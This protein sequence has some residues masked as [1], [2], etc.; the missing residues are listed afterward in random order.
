MKAIAK[1]DL[2]YTEK[3]LGNY[4]PYA[5]FT[6]DNKYNVCIDSKYFETIIADDEN[7]EVH[8]CGEPKDLED[9]FEFIESEE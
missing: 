5:K 3:D 9:K 4:I 8:F 2:L 6:K 1:Q 7:R